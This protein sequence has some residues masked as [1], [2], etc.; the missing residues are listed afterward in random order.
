MTNRVPRS[1]TSRCASSNRRTRSRGKN[2]LATTEAP[3]CR[4]RRRRQSNRSE[5]R[6]TSRTRRGTRPAAAGRSAR[7]GSFRL[8]AGPASDPGRAGRACGRTSLAR[9]GRRDGG[10]RAALRWRGFDL[11]RRGAEST[12]GW[13]LPPRHSTTICRVGVLTVESCNPH[14]L[15]W[16]QVGTDELVEIVHAPHAT[17]RVDQSDQPVR[18][19]TTEAGG[20][21]PPSEPFRS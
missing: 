8:V 18:L 2:G 7:R 3:G 16:Q 11:G 14:F 1:R 15:T 10:G 13:R 6:S 12:V 4:S 20:K 9:E 5:R 17:G 19:P 21:L